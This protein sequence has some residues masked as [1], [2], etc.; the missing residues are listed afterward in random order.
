MCGRARC[1]L[2]R[3]KAATAAGVPVDKWKDA[4]SFEPAENIHP[5]M[6]A[7]V[8]KENEEGEREIQTMR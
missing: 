3:E 1:T 2:S 6:R 4:E 5:G 8:V 7:P